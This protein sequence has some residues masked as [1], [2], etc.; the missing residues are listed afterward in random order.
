MYRYARKKTGFLGFFINI[1]SVK[2]VFEQFVAS[3]KAPLKYLLTY[4][5]SQDHLELFFSAVRSKGGYNNNPTVLQFKSAY[6]LPLMR[7]HIQCTENCAPIDDSHILSVY[8]GGTSKGGSSDTL[9]I[10]NAHK[11]N[12]IGNGPSQSDHDYVGV[13]S[14][15]PLSEYKEA[16]LG[17]IA[18]YAVKM[19]RKKTHCASCQEALTETD[20]INIDTSSFLVEKDRGGFIHASTRVIKICCETEKC[21]Q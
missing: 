5:L 21:F 13:P 19:A 2:E 17:Y 4:K 14:F 6:K 9:Y 8:D 11:F 12:L 20:E 18:G 10:K 15:L 3:E 7:H 1:N 16:A